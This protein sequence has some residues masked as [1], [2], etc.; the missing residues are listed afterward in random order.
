MLLL[1]TLRGT[2]TL[3]YGDE[4]GMVDVPV[5]TED[6]RDPLERREPGRGRDPE[7]SPMQWDAS[8]NA[9]FCAG[10]ADS[11]LPLAAN[12]D[13]VNV[14]AQAEDPGSL[15][16]LTRRLLHVRREHPAL[17]AGD[18]EAF[19]P[20]PEGTYAFLRGSG[21]A[22]LTVVVNLTGEPRRVPGVGRG[23]VLIGTHPDRD[24]ADIADVVEL[25]PNE[26]VVVEAV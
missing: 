13:R 22:R 17:G 25:Q 3:Y 24:G 14:E 23:R 26:G 4:I 7:R 1:L 10:N 8:P 20:T 6:S 16:T 21:D 18:F 2:P 9:G 11:W 5:A 19:G 12:A 15:L